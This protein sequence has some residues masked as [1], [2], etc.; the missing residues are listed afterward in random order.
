[1]SQSILHTHILCRTSITQLGIQNFSRNSQIILLYPIWTLSTVL[2]YSEQNLDYPSENFGVSWFCLCWLTLRAIMIIY[3]REG[4]LSNWTWSHCSS[5][6]HKFQQV[7][8]LQEFSLKIF[9][10]AT[11]LVWL[12]TFELK[13]YLSYQVEAQHPKNQNIY[14]GQPWVLKNFPH[15]FS[16]L[17]LSTGFFFFHFIPSIIIH[18]HMLYSSALSEI[19]SIVFYFLN[20]VFLN[21]SIKIWESFWFREDI[22]HFF[23][24]FNNYT[25]Q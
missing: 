18:K 10:L 9:S 8:S 25:V 15:L 7:Q 5:D 2:K 6:Q 19:A 23:S 4:I 16:I 22:R 17:Q 1:M 20:I 14:H 12:L 3:H 13:F 21:S 11:R 24:N